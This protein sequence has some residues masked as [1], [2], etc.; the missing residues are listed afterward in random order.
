MGAFM[1]TSVLFP[2]GRRFNIFV[3]FIMGII[4]LLILFSKFS[5]LEPLAYKILL[6]GNFIVIIQNIVIEH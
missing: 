2:L 1:F 5:N 3:T 4:E 6:N